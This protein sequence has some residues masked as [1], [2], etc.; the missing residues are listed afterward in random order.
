MVIGER[1]R[2]LRKEKGLSQGD[3][4]HRTGL[5]RCY[6]SRVENGHTVP[7]VETIEKLARALEVPLYQLFF[8]G[9]GA[10]ADPAPALARVE[11]SGLWGSSGDDAREFAQFRRALSRATDKDRQLLLSVAN[12]M[13]RRA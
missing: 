6:L 8:D 9:E 5:F 11:D 7:S 10:P 2:S 3:I 4:E 13:A 12:R 1:L